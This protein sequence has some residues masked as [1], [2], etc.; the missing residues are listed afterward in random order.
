MDRL[1][2]LVKPVTSASNINK[3]EKDQIELTMEW[4]RKLGHALERHPLD[5]FDAM[6]KLPP[7]E[8]ALVERYRGL[9]EDDQR[10]IF[11]IADAMAEQV[12]RGILSSAAAPPA[13]VSTLRDPHQRSEQGGQP[14]HRGKR[15]AH[16]R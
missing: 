5:F 9:S 12:N 16:Q 1:A 11:R 6:P 7:E 15:R 2:K 8:T 13:T 10:T 4:A 14:D 3:L